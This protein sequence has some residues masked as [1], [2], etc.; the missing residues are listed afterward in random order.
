MNRQI[1]EEASDWL[2]EF[3]TEEPDTSAR[4]RF[5][6][7]LGRSPEHVQAYL[8][9]SGIW[10]TVS[11][12]PQ[13]DA[14]DIEALI[15][16]ARS[17]PS[18]VPLSGTPP[19]NRA[20]SPKIVRSTGTDHNRS[21]LVFRRRGLF[22]M[23]ATLLLTILG[24]GI[25]LHTQRNVYTT[26]IGEQRSILLS[27]GSTIDLNAKSRIRVQLTQ[28]E[29]HID[30]LQ[31]QALFRVAHD[32]TR[33]FIVT[34]N[35][36][37]VRAVGTEFDINQ[38][39]HGLIVTV[40]EGTVAVL[41]R[42]PADAR[43]PA[44]EREDILLSAGQQITV[45]AVAPGSAGTHPLKPQRA[46]VQTATGWTQRRLIFESTP[47]ADVAEEFNRNNAR[48]LV[49]EGKGLEDFHVSGAFSSTDPQP[50]LRFLR[51]Q[52]GITVTDQRDKIV[53]SRRD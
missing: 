37:H 49:I 12:Q 43:A 30:L 20:S 32:K 38:R 4:R 14:V 47:L 44:L 25:Y 23:A 3:R 26:A 52:A 18:I 29:R 39:K 1:Y 40:L 2:L 17:R 27:D 5:Q 24:V 21:S 6:G 31:G 35:G 51:A 50:L 9:L 36:T 10:E 15:E 45:A 28:H 53:V 13:A 8:E 34:A 7:W 41:E 22:A 46:D 33:P 42:E 11:A 19:D 48:P 16:R